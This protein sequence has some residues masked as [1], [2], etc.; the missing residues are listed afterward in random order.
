[1]RR[2]ALFIVGL[3]LIAL[4][5]C[6]RTESHWRDARRIGTVAAYEQFLAQHPAGA[7]ADEARRKL[8]DL[9]WEQAEQRSTIAGYQ[10]FLQDHPQSRRAEE[11]KGRVE[12]MA[13]DAKPFWEAVD[14]CTEAALKRFLRNYPGHTLEREAQRILDELAQTPEIAGN[15]VELVNRGKME[16]DARGNGPE[17]VSLRVRKR[18]PQSVALTVPVGTVF[19]AAASDRCNVVAVAESS[20][21]LPDVNWQTVSLPVLSIDRQ[22]AAPGAS[23]TFR[24]VR[25]EPEQKALR[26]IL[27]ALGRAQ[28]NN[29]ARQVAVWIITDDPTYT[30]LTSSVVRSGTFRPVQLASDVA[31]GMKLCDELGV[32][33]T[34]KAIWRDRQRVLRVLGNGSLRTWLCSDELSWRAA[35]ARNTV[36]GYNELLA[37]NPQIRNADE[38]RRRIAR[39]LVDDIPFVAAR[40]KGT[41]GAW[42]EFLDEFP[43][44]ARKAEAQAAYRKARGVQ[45]IVDLIDQ[46]KIA[47]DIEGSG[48]EN[49]SVRVR[50]LVPESVVVYIP[51]GTFFVSANPSAQS[52]VGTREVEI[53]LED[54]KW[55]S[56]S[57]RA[58]CANRTRGIP[59]SSDRFSVQR[60]P[61]QQDLARL[62]PVLE[63]AGVSSSVRQAAV[64]IVTD[65]ANYEALGIL[66]SGS[67]GGFGGTRLIDRMDA[68]MAMKL[69]Q[70]AGVDMT[71][72]AIWRDR[73]Q[74]YHALED[75]PVKAWL[76]AQR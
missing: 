34:R 71:R 49:V 62:M 32:D 69:C 40:E 25:S 65:D 23:D 3:L 36:A 31:M 22:K 66:V 15:L 42:K 58:A 52:M 6:D 47:V 18:T 24:S 10:K 28:V 35:E 74:I 1:M 75:G 51:V 54:D 29:D 12:A 5:G 33:I 70:E 55:Q 44:H 45:D 13:S 2:T 19:V 7:R 43:G 20:L 21:K 67:F 56:I 14:E 76:G 53:A 38:A 50:K 9:R 72:K 27:P 48:I 4:A 68:A 60:A 30:A 46:R 59:D 57:V 64:W 11:A 61:Q 37:G 73:F 41:A 8:E 39:L 26:A 63:R 17:S 16:C